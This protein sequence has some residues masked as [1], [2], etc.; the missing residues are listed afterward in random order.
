MQV[1]FRYISLLILTVISLFSCTEKIDLDIDQQAYA[2]LVVDGQITTNKSNNWIKLSKTG[3]YF[4]NQPASPVTGATIYVTDNKYNPIQFIES[5]K[6]GYYLPSTDITGNIGETYQLKIELESEVGHYKIFESTV[7]EMKGSIPPDSIQLLYKQESN[8]WIIKAFSWDSIGEDYYL[9][10]VYKNG[11]LLTDSIHE[12]SVWDDRYFNGNYSTGINVQELDCT[13][14]E[15]QLK[16]G[17][18][19]TLEVSSITEDYYKFL[20]EYQNQLSGCDPM[21]SGPSANI[22]SNINNGAIGFFSVY[23]KKTVSKVLSGQ[24]E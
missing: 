7:Q 16:P 20:K 2:R 6:P 19:I 14:A 24:F 8:S 12:F 15:A 23:S 21:F 5:D 17:D 1:Q 3:D 10:K 11:I 18:E 13:K 4:D 22:S 9:F